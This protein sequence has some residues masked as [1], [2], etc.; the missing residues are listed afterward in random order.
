MDADP[1]SDTDESCHFHT[2]AERY[3]H[4]DARGGPDRIGKSG[5]GLGRCPLAHSQLGES[6]GTAADSGLP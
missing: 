2:D 6:K 1:Y 3:A 4:R 5:G